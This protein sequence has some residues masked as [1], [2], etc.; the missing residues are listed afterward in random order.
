MSEVPPS[1][2]HESNLI[3]MLLLSAEEHYHE[4]SNAALALGSLFCSSFTRLV[5]LSYNIMHFYLQARNPPDNLFS[6]SESPFLSVA[7][8]LWSAKSGKPDGDPFGLPNQ[9]RRR[10]HQNRPKDYYLSAGNSVMARPQD[11]AL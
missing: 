9:L 4:S 6:K 3:V 7:Q 5:S 10:I 1:K 8:R 11:W 2:H